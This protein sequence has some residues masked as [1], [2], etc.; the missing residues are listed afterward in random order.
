MSVN[1]NGYKNKHLTYAKSL[2]RSTNEYI[3]ILKSATCDECTTQSKE[4]FTGSLL[5][6]RETEILKL[7]TEKRSNAE[8]AAEL[9]I[10]LSAVKQHNSRIFDKLG[11][12]NRHE[13]VA[14]AREL[15]II[16]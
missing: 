9:F 15:R 14:R 2:L 16:E 8:I 1:R 4:D 7:L 13:A 6:K 3:T 11:V 10:S 12:K 5:S